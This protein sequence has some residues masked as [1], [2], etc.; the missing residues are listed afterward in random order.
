MTDQTT[1]IAFR[2][3]FAEHELNNDPCS[4]V[5]SYLGEYYTGILGIEEHNKYGEKIKKHFHYHF[6]YS[7]DEVSAG[8]F[9]N[10]V[11]KRI[12]RA[13]GESPSGKRGKGYY[14]ITAPDVEDLDRWLRYPLKQ[15]PTFDQIY[16]NTRIP[17]PPEF[18]LYTQWTCATEEYL[19]DREFLSS[20]REK[21]D[22]RQTT[23]QKILVSIQETNTRFSDMRSICRYIISYYMREELP[24]ER[25]KIRSMADSIAMMYGILSSDVYIDMILA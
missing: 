18:D 24:V 10:T 1:P 20:R 11:R 19:R 15:V 7:G 5:A 14:S 8:K 23:F 2:Y 17:V 16:K 22:R 4:I 6:L 13:N 12:I 3:D 25:Q 9:I 21:E